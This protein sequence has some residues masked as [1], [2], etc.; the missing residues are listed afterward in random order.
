[1]TQTRLNHRLLFIAFLA[2]LGIF[3]GL[4]EASACESGPRSCCSSKQ[5]GRCGGCCR[6]ADVSAP[7]GTMERVVSPHV[8]RVQSSIRT[9]DCRSHDPAAPSSKNE[10][11]KNEQRTDDARTDDLITLEVPFFQTVTARLGV[12][13]VSLTFEPLYLRDS[14]L[15]L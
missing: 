10:S 1:M 15:N 9:C 8:G 5:A 11:Q 13:S 6:D 4:G 14:R 3:S 2:M 7:T 12:H